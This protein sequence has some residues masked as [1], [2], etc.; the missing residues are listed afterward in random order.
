MLRSDEDLPARDRWARLRLAIIGGL[1]ASPPAEGEP[2][3]VASRNFVTGCL[4]EDVTRAR[5]VVID[6]LKPLLPDKR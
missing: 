2:P 1:L 6:R 4:I 3:R 5:G